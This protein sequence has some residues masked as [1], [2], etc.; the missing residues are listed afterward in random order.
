MP[1]LNLFELIWADDLS[2]VSCPFE[3]LRGRKFQFNC[4]R[5]P[6]SIGLYE[7]VNSSQILTEYTVYWVLRVILK[8]MPILISDHVALESMP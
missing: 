7:V 3:W 8:R 4:S 5:K 6:D 2:V 1:V